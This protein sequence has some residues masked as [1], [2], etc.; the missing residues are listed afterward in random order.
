MNAM[1]VYKSIVCIFYTMASCCVPCL[2]QSQLVA[3]L[4]QINLSTW[5]TCGLYVFN[6][7][8]SRTYVKVGLSQ[9]R[10][11]GG[12]F[13]VLAECTLNNVAEHVNYL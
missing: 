6:A 5:C 2:M 1:E 8:C 7:E 3:H 10:V 4:I 12:Y 11:N 13:S 9:S